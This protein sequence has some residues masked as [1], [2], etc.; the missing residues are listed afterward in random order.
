MLV[1]YTNAPTSAFTPS[2]CVLFLVLYFFPIPLVQ[3]EMEG[4]SI[5]LG[6]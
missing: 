1:A 5:Q 4:D 2:H 3:G 6:V